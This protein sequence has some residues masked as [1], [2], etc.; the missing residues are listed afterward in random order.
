MSGCMD[1]VC[2]DDDLA[3]RFEGTDDACVARMMRARRG[4]SV[5][6]GGGCSVKMWM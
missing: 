5:Q 1:D 4:C 3:L 6:G 2:W